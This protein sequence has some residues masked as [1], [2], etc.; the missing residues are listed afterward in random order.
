M[1]F[2]LDPVPILLQRVRLELADSFRAD[3]PIRFSRAPGRLDVMGGIAEYTGS[4]VCQMTLD[5]AAAVALQE[6]GDRELQVFSF[7]LLDEHK[8]FTLRVPLDS[9][10]RH[11]AETLRKEF[12]EP[13]RLWA[14]DLAGCLHVLH[15]R[16]FVDLLNP[17]VHGLNLAMLSTVPQGAGVGSSAAIQVATMM[18]LVDHFGVR[19][20]IDPLTLAELCRA[21]ENRIVGV[22]CG[23]VDRVTSG[24]G[25]SD[26][27]SR[28]LCQPCE[29]QSPLG[30][31]E[32]MRV[33]G[34]DSSVRSGSGVMLSARTRCAAFMGHKIILEKMREIGR[35]ANRILERDPMDGYLANLTPDDYKKFFRP[36]LP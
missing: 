23:M 18:N 20:R 25:K 17:K 22:P 24:S 8:P 35:A 2:D 12:A 32:G 15:E 33:L 31:P 7:N 10:V 3:R 6:R 19:D 16:G 30:L 27:L 9:L 13:G 1:L 26:L 5:C 29:M 34:I 28:L 11:S 4:L 36:Y 21:V 14:G